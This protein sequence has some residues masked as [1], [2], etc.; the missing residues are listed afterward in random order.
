[1][2]IRKSSIKEIWKVPEIELKPFANEVKVTLVCKEE[3]V[4]SPI[5][6]VKGI[7]EGYKNI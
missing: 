3:K 1:L 6:N 4:E 2:Y 5:S 7:E